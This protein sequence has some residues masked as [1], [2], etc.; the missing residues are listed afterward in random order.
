M[1]IITLAP[2]QVSDEVF[3]SRSQN[4]HIIEI[5]TTPTWKEMMDI[6]FCGRCTSSSRAPCTFVFGHRHPTLF[7]LIC[8]SPLSRLGIRGLEAA[9]PRYPVNLYSTHR[10]RNSHNFLISNQKCTNNK[11]GPFLMIQEI[12]FADFDLDQVKRVKSKWGRFGRFLASH[13]FVSISLAAGR[14]LLFKYPKKSLLYQGINDIIGLNIKLKNQLQ[15]VFSVQLS[16]S[17]FHFWWS[18]LSDICLI[19]EQIA[20]IDRTDFML[21]SHIHRAKYRRTD[22]P[23]N[24]WYNSCV[25]I[26][27]LTYRDCKICLLTNWP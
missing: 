21:W 7:T 26:S 16:S 18:C 6:L 8:F 2:T 25:I 13:P 27:C 24:L 19:L 14:A 1:P 3:M 10:P 20:S 22:R 4:C 5:H 9:T 12:K 17:H 15:C 23:Q 11:I